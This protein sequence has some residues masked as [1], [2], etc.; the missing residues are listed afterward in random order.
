MRAERGG[1]Q[2]RTVA[3]WHKGSLSVLIDEDANHYRNAA[4]HN[5]WHFNPET[6]CI[7][8]QD[9]K[10]K[11]T[12]RTCALALQL[13]NVLHNSLCIYAAIY[14]PLMIMM[15]QAQQCGILE[16]IG[17]GD[18]SKLDELKIAER[19]QPTIDRLKS[20]MR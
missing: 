6:D 19:L 2:L 3:A 12:Y 1:D 18:A 15:K 10:W 13:E 14:R 4:A 7:E 5:H 11:K 9:K 8:L 20:L 17:T 16:A